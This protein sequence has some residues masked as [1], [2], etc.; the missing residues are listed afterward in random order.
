MESESPIRPAA[1]TAGWFWKTLACAALLWCVGLTLIR[2]LPAVH[3]DNGGASAGGYIALMGIQ[4]NDE[5]LYIVDTHNNTLLMYETKTNNELNFV[6]G[7]SFQFDSSF[8]SEQKG[9][10]LK[11]NA[12]GYDKEVAEFAKGLK[13]P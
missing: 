12:K 5:H 11:Y 3:A 1:R 6:T 7:R 2:E 10:F 8:L 4:P 13:T 9:K